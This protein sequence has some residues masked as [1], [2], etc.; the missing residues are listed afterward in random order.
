MNAIRITDLHKVYREGFW[1]RK[2]VGLQGISFTVPEG[3][4]FGFLGANGAGKTTAIKIALGLQKADAGSVEIFGSSSLTV[5]TKSQLGYLP[6]RPYLHLNLTATEFLNFHRSLHSG[7]SRKGKFL[8]NEELLKLVNLADV[9]NVLLRNFSKGMLQRIGIAQ[10]LINDPRLVILD[11][12][13]SGLD[14]VG[15]REVRNLLLELNRAGKTVFF[16]SHILSDIESLCEQIAFLEKGS[17]KYFG[18]VEELLSRGSQEVEIL[19]KC[20][21]TLA[22]LAE[23]GKV[24]ALGDWKKILVQEQD[25][26]K[27]V[28]AIWQSKGE[29][30][31]FSPVHKN[32]EE[33][34]FGENRP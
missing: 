9:K 14:P 26:Q 8:S 28:E 6:E 31:S 25:C 22:S 16:S 13:M 12:P 24:S 3:K 4:I 27:V 15:R 32:L 29:V 30:K 5:D 2:R 20:Q 10:S 1:G 7:S 34:L 17:L 11:E 19:F 21:Q 18:G 33:A 23:W